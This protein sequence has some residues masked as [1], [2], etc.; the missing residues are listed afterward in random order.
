VNRCG[1]GCGFCGRCDSG[2]PFDATCEDCGDGFYLGRWDIGI[3][4]CESCATKRETWADEFDA[5]IA[6]EKRMAKADL[7]IVPKKKDVA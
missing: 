4:H 5:R 3:T 2:G 7:T 6:N 1:D